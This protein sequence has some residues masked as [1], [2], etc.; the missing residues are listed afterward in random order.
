MYDKTH[1][2]TCEYVLCAAF[3]AGEFLDETVYEWEDL[4]PP[5]TKNG[6]EFMGTD[7]NH[8]FEW[9]AKEKDVK[10]LNL[11]LAKKYP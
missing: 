8:P 1:H 6:Y 5:I 7:V 3:G 9:W 2:C 10:Q 11:L 4:W